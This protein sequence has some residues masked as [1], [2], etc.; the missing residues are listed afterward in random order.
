M[1][2]LVGA[3]IAFL[4]PI[5]IA[6]VFFVVSGGIEVL[7]FLATY[8]CYYSIVRVLRMQLTARKKTK[9]DWL[10]SLS[11]SA[12]FGLTT[13]GL[14]PIGLFIYMILTGKPFS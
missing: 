8:V 7:L 3:L 6:V 5:I 10:A 12:L 4:L 14:L 11:Y 13:V 1:G 2:C 9:G